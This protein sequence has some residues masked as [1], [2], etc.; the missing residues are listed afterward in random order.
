MRCCCCNFTIQQK[1]GVKMIAMEN[2]FQ[3]SE[4]EKNS[5]SQLFFCAS[6]VCKS[7]KYHQ[8]ITLWIVREQKRVIRKIKTVVFCIHNIIQ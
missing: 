5:L 2:Q 1:N 4:M 3:L 7:K 6:F 8:Q